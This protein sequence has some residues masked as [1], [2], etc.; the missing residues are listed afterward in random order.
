[1][2]KIKWQGNFYEVPE[3]ELSFYPGYEM[4]SNEEFNNVGKQN[5]PVKETVIAGS[6]NQ[7]VVMDSNLDPG[8][9]GSAPSRASVLANVTTP[10]ELNP[11]AFTENPNREELIKLEAEYNATMADPKTMNSDENFRKRKGLEKQIK[12]LG[13]F[14]SIAQV[15]LQGVDVVQKKLTF[16]EI[17]LQ[18]QKNFGIVMD[19]VLEDPSIYIDQLHEEGIIDKAT[20][21]KTFN[22]LVKSPDPKVKNEL[23][24]AIKNRA[25]N[26]YFNETSR[27]ESSKLPQK[28]G[29]LIVGDKTFVRDDLPSSDDLEAIDGIYG[30]KMSEVLSQEFE[31]AN[32]ININR[33]KKLEEVGDYEPTLQ[34]AYDSFFFYNP[35]DQRVKNLGEK[36]RDL[37]VRLEDKNL[38]DQ[39]RR[40]TN[41]E[42]LQ[43]LEAYDPAWK[44]MNERRGGEGQAPYRNLLTNKFIG[45]YEAGQLNDDEKTQDTEEYKA[46]LDNYK[47]YHFDN[48]ERE[49]V[50]RQLDQEEFDLE[51]QETVD[52]VVHKGNMQAKIL[53]DLGYTLEEVD[54]ENLR[55][56]Q[57]LDIAVGKKG[58]VIVRGVKYKDI[59]DHLV[60]Y[61][62]SQ[63]SIDTSGEMKFLSADF[64]KIAG[65]DKDNKTFS[66]EQK[67]KNL[68]EEKRTLGL[69]RHA[70]E[71]MW[72][73]NN[74]PARYEKISG[75]QGAESAFKNTIAS[76]VGFF[77]RSKTAEFLK[78]SPV[79]TQ[80]ETLDEYRNFLNDANIP[81]S[82]EQEKNLK[83]SIMFELGVETLPAF[84]ADLVKFAI[85]TRGA[86][87]VGANSHISN[88][89]RQGKWFQGFMATNV[90]EGVKFAAVMNDKDMFFNGFFF[91]AG[92]QAA[93]A[94]LP[95][96]KKIGLAHY[97]RAYKKI[98]GGGA[99]MM[100]GSEVEQFAH[101]L[102]DSMMGDKALKTSMEELYGELSDY[103]RR[104][105]LNFGTGAAL[106][107]QKVNIKADVAGMTA[108]RNYLIQIERNIKDK[109]YKGKELEKKLILREHLNRDFQIYDAKFNE[110]NLGEQTEDANVAREIIESGSIIIKNPETGSIIES[111]TATSKE[112]KTAKELV[113][114]YEFNKKRVKEEL[115]KYAEEVKK[116]EIFGKDFKFEL[117]E[118]DADFLG[119]G[120][121]AEYVESSN[122]MIIDLKKFRPGVFAQEIGHAMMRAAFGKNQRA[123]KLF[124]NKILETV[125]TK[126]KGETFNVKDENG[127]IFEGLTFEQ[128]IKKAYPDKSQRPEEY[129]MNVVEFLSNPKYQH[130]L[131][132]KGLINDI[133]RTTL[134]TANRFNMDYSNAKNFKTGE[135]MLEFLFSIGKIAEGGSAKALQNKFKAFKN[136]IIDGSRLYNKT[137]GKEIKGEEIQEFKKFNSREIKQPEKDIPAEYDIQRIKTNIEL[138]KEVGNVFVRQ[139][140]EQDLQR[141]LKRAEEVEAL[142][143]KSP[144][145][146]RTSLELA[147][148]IGNVIVRQRNIKDLQYALTVQQKRR[149]PGNVGVTDPITGKPIKG[150]NTGVMFSKEI[151]PEL[152]APK[153]K[154]VLQAIKD[155]VPKNIK[156]K[157]EYDAWATSPRG[158]QKL[159]DAFSPAG[160]SN[161]SFPK[162]GGPIFNYIKSGKTKAESDKTLMDVLER[163][164]K[165][166]PEATRADGTKV[167][168]AGFGER[169]FADAAWARLT[170]RK[171][172]FDAG[173]KQK[174][175]RRI[176]DNDFQI[177]DN[178]VR[179]RIEPTTKGGTPSIIQTNLKVNGKRITGEGTQLRKDFLKEADAVLEKVADLGFKPGDRGFRKAL[180]N[181]IKTNNPKLFE[182]FKEEL[183]DYNKLI[184]ENYNTVLTNKKAIE[185]EFYVQAEKFRA[186]KGE[187]MFVQKVKRATKQAEIR[188]AIR[189][190]K[191]TYTE[192]EAQGVLVYNRLNPPKAKGLEFFKIPN[193]KKRLLETLYKGN[194]VDAV[195]NQSKTKKIYSTN[196]KAQIAEKFQKERDTYYSAEI[197]EF[198]QGTSYKAKLYGEKGYYKNAKEELAGIKNLI[199]QVAKSK[200][201]YTKELLLTYLENSNIAPNDGMRAGVGKFIGNG[202]IKTKEGI[203]KE[204]VAELYDLGELTNSKVVQEY[205]IK[206]LGVKDLTSGQGTGTKYLKRTSGKDKKMAANLKQ[207]GDALRKQHLGKMIDAMA[208][209]FKMNQQASANLFYNQNARNGINRQASK[210]EF[211]YT[212][213][214][215]QYFEHL[216]QN[217]FFNET[218]LNISKAKTPLI[219]AKLKDMLVDSYTQWI[220]PEKLAKILDKSYQTDLGIWNAKKDPH[221]FLR[222]RAQEIM[223]G[224]DVKAPSAVT[225]IF[226]EQ[227]IKEAGALLNPFA[228]KNSKGQSYPETLGINVPKQFQKIQEVQVATS[229]LISDILFERTND[230]KG[231]IKTLN[232]MLPLHAQQ[233]KAA[234]KI[235][236]GQT[237]VYEQAVLDGAAK[238]KAAKQKQIEKYNSKDISGEFNSYLEKSTG[239]KKEAVFGA[240]TAMA[241]GKQAKTD[242]GDYF[243][244]VGAEDFA[245]LMHK[246]LARGKQG[247]KQLEFYQKTLYDP[248]NRAVEAMTN[249]A[250]AL[251]NDFKALKKQL[252][253]VPKTLKEFTDSGVFTKEQA[254]RVAIWN[255]LGYEIPGI[256]NKVKAELLKTVKDNAELNTFANEIIKMTKGDGYAKP[257]ESWVAGNIA[258]DMVELLNTTKR[259][260]H[261]EVWQNNVD[262]VFSK[263]NLFKLEAA[264]GAKY[265]KTLKATLARMKSGSNRKW[266]ANETVEKWNDWIN[267]SVGA[268]MFLNTRSAVL[269]TISNINYL[270]FKD[271]NPL[272]AAKA[273]ANQKQYWTDFNT[274]FNSQYL[275]S[276]RGGNKINVNES[277][278]ALAQQKGGVQGVI[279][280]MLNKGFVLTR[281]ADSF[282]IATG[283][284]SMYRNR[285][286]SYKKQGFSE[287]EAKEK[288]FRDFMK[289]TEETQQS[290]RPDRISE[291]QASNLGRFMLAFANTPMQYNRIIKRNLQDLIA[292]RG[293][294]RDKMTKITYYG[295]IQ[296]IIFNALSKALF[297][298]AF[299][300]EEDDK[301]QERTI[302][303]GEGMLD[304]LLRGSG[305]YGNAAVAV[306]NTAKA[307][308]TNRQDPELQALTISPPL[309]SKVSKLR[310]AFYTRKYITKNNMFEPSLDNPA[311]NAGAQFSSAVFNF[312]LDR[313]IR[314][315]QNLDAA[316]SEGPEY[317]QRVALSL[318]WAEW[319]LGIEDDKPKK[320][321]K[322]VKTYSQKS[323]KK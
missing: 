253:N 245:G 206:K 6:E 129:V 125:N 279:A 30:E 263:E 145:E 55:F 102:V 190:K 71:E 269:Q 34:R 218:V 175:E 155:L 261:L 289:I 174:Q 320:R 300:D 137:T 202:V 98:M 213:T 91:G 97:D 180:A 182:R 278:L 225:R 148:D 88:L 33:T 168:I 68:H 37:K 319:E 8:F 115:F 11:V 111:R 178:V 140:I 82:K 286:N 322:K 72:I 310:N 249:E 86:G 100:A 27:F 292:G 298:S 110:R 77:D 224:K 251:K 50:L 173:E 288:A 158:G 272:Q 302:K 5:D 255:K 267:G 60:D 191:A 284:A 139:R 241:R 311:L 293:D 262:Q 75:L 20:G 81:L 227:I 243:I 143:N 23:E 14:E 285:L 220:V 44:K 154:D 89:F 90:L 294:P 76:F 252:T 127:K 12:E 303:V 128:A 260:K 185:L 247:E 177:A 136:I 131:L 214:K 103:D 217:G 108:R 282:A 321:K 54:K 274:L 201:P 277:E 126:L 299:S 31:A 57:K 237:G 233:S 291:Q 312:P 87:A 149:F 78:H 315:A 7:A 39:D 176:E 61:S 313:A 238:N 161:I 58:G 132:E 99:G 308:A 52:I 69:R 317:W 18:R 67:V 41:I 66:I 232:K 134:L 305:L 80:R 250:M 96:L 169:I 184:N 1:M 307:I 59:M 270:N 150:K 47:S 112:I 85:A 223:E 133:K 170:S 165:F 120:N 2:L 40:E 22:D 4:A 152:T 51:T 123:A 248:Y 159:G 264:Y 17:N 164:M 210:V 230:I 297:V 229:K 142:I 304:T 189:T 309:Y 65:I 113:K 42:L 107:T 73:L 266:G 236:K 295:M 15:N 25:K 109:K 273:F 287:K 193:V 146:L 268:I 43:A 157:E 208:E 101:A 234:L 171:E 192:N 316:M 280:L 94:I 74:D 265:V 114:K 93:G 141:E 194:L 118:G 254:V 276:R 314:K 186:N 256:S 83:R 283:G 318:G 95:S 179:S 228:A 187:N 144:E 48:L 53:E 124:R 163:T 38:S 271:N 172:L 151:T 275:Q 9:S 258:M 16:D 281:M 32:Q 3:D 135:Q 257:K 92:S 205:A 160:K 49:A 197:T 296:N 226:N 106:G 211:A 215:K 231:S 199:D 63:A 212:Q 200:N 64:F 301:Q 162:K 119:K 188:E 36:I 221:P 84:S 246:T 156:T 70:L 209:M 24:K 222:E 290:S 26:I 239:I 323:I 104:M 117:K 21:Y 62:G 242:F 105:I 207:G 167:G 56:D 138:N 29:K 116:S 306:K 244:P 259:T 204:R 130:L 240:A 195:I 147:K 166:N 181:V 35:D 13:G 19:Q 198:K 28:Y 122:T 45:T 216:L 121:K 235:S 203:K 79:V 219:A 10:D 153:R 46:I 196:E 183:G